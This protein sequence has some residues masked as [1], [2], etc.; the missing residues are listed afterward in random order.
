MTTPD[1]VLLG[2][3]QVEITSMTNDECR[4]WLAEHSPF[5]TAAWEGYTV[6]QLRRCVR[7]VAHAEAQR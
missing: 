5:T 3:Q 6:A 4:D 1:T 7:L 2:K